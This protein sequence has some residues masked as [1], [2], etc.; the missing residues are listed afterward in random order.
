MRVFNGAT[1]A[2]TGTVFLGILREGEVNSNHI[3]PSFPGARGSNSGINS[4]AHRRY[5]FHAVL[6]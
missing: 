1:P 2:R 6:R 4:S 5:Q 3:V